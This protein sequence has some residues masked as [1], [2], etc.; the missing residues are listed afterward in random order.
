MLSK[1][2]QTINETKILCRQL[3]IDMQTIRIN[4]ENVK[5]KIAKE[6]YHG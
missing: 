1:I 2:R 3:I 6:V 5:D 4:L